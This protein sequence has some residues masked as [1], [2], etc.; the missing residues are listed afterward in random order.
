VHNHERALHF[1]VKE[2]ARNEKQFLF[3]LPF[4]LNSMTMA[5]EI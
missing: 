5:A 1:N 3:A 4:W 2:M